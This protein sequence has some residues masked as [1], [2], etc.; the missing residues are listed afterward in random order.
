MK[1]TFALVKLLP[2]LFLI[3]GTLG[4]DPTPPPAGVIPLGVT[5]IQLRAV[6]AGWS[7]KKDVLGKHVQNSRKEDLGKIEDVV[8]TPNDQVAFA[9]IGV[10]GFLGIAERLVAIPA[11]QLKAENGYFLLPGATKDVLSAMPPFIYAH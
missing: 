4:A 10:G 7:V 11:S 5:V 8:I 1:A 2:A 6:V 3:T 9:I